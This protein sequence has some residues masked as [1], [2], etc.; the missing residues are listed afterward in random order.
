MLMLH[1]LKLIGGNSVLDIEP[2]TIQ[3]IMSKK[4]KDLVIV[5]L[6]LMASSAFSEFVLGVVSLHISLTI[7]IGYLLA[8][9][10]DWVGLNK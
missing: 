5:F 4:I 1:H 3:K 9:I 6:G 7:F 10:M 2:R 8:R